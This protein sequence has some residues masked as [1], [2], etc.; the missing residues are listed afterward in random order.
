M[1]SKPDVEMSSAGS[2]NIEL[3]D[4]ELPKAGS[5][6]VESPNFEPPDVESLNIQSPKPD[7]SNDE[8]S[9]DKFSDIELSDAESPTAESPTAEVPTIKIPSTPR[10][11]I[12]AERYPTIL[13]S[14]LRT[15]TEVYKTRPPKQ[16]NEC[17][18]QR[19]SVKSTKYKCYRRIIAHGVHP[20]TFAE[21]SLF[22]FWPEYD[23]KSDL[24]Y[25][26]QTYTMLDVRGCGSFGTVA[27]MLSK[28]DG[29][30]YA[31]KYGSMYRTHKD[32][33]LQLREV[34]FLQF[35]NHPNCVRFV[36]AWEETD[37]LHMQLELCEMNLQGYM[38]SFN[39][40]V[41]RQ[42][43]SN[44]LLDILRAL[45]YLHSHSIVH[46]DVKPENILFDSH[47]I[48]KLSDFGMAFD[49]KSDD[50]EV[51][52]VEGDSR[53][54]ALEALI[55]G[56]KRRVTTKRDVYSLGVTMLQLATDLHIPA[57]GNELDDIRALKLSRLIR[58]S[59]DLLNLVAQMMCEDPAD[60]PE[61]QEILDMDGVK[62]CEAVRRRFV[63]EKLGALMRPGQRSPDWISNAIRRLQEETRRRPCSPHPVT[64][65]FSPLKTPKRRHFAFS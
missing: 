6:K 10:T 47:E 27:A 44:V 34:V 33:Y 39:G 16:Y 36:M 25:L 41:P 32:R 13:H 61:A 62:Q 49:L 7:L 40:K 37:R 14:E 11:P 43:V 8:L 28:V 23:P 51:C 64:L 9:N 29:K 19:S 55:D 38:I 18:L 56:D 22:T 26:G 2:P 59:D 12:I 24:D 1:D 50:S 42:K 31:I 15:Q 17:V 53:Y 48:A 58:I 63:E 52:R 60:R 45:S 65:P 4:V 21:P 20:V 5:P 54:M 30:R 35:I 57:G 3:P 46:L